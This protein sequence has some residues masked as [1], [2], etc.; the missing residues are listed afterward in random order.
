MDRAGSDMHPVAHFHVGSRSDSHANHPVLINWSASTRSFRPTSK[1]KTSGVSEGFFDISQL[2]IVLMDPERATW[3]KV[4]DTSSRPLI[5]RSRHDTAP[6]VPD[7]SHGWKRHLDHR[8]PGSN[9]G[10]G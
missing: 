2:E 5:D 6:A 9:G 1:N 8:V 7:G 4:L 3:R 10:V